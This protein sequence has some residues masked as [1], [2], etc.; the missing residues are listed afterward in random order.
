MRLIDSFFA[1][2]AEVA[3]DGRCFV[4]G[5]GIEGL[6][7]PRLNVAIPSLTMLARIHFDLE[8]CNKDHFFTLRA[9]SPEGNDLGVRAAMPIRPQ[10]SDHFPERGVTSQVAVI[11]YG[12]PLPVA[13][14][15]AFD[16]LVN[17]QAIGQRTLGVAVA[18]ND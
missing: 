10:P 4:L 12:L 18:R 7:V 11:I 14:L 13:G 16:L 8:E 5:G 15:Y 2:A 3:Q 17:G 9:T 6:M 1:N